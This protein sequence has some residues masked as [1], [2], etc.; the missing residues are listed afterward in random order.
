MNPIAKTSRFVSFVAGFAAIVA[1]G[2][3][4]TGS[5]EDKTGTL[6]ITFKLKGDAPKLENIEP[7]TDK[8]FCGKK[9]IPDESLV[10]NKKNK[11]IKN[12]IVYKYVSSRDIDRNAEIKNPKPKVVT[13]A[14][15]ACRFE[16]HVV[17][18][19]VQ[20]TI[21]VT[22]PDAVGHNANFTFIRNDQQNPTVPAGGSV[23]VVTTVNEPAPI[24]VTCNIHNWMKAYVLVLHPDHAYAG[25]SDADGVLEI[26][27][28]P[29]GEEIE[30]RANHE[31]GSLKEVIVGGK[32][33]EWSRSRFELTIKEGLNDMGV[34]E[35]PADAFKL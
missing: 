23:D 10:V 29:V 19:T 21:K 33:T 32:E 2:F 14:N 1:I 30:F 18:T 5:A 3:A 9:D 20:D 4:S 7:T 28:L 35:V 6:R 13:L 11:G 27:G 17:I 8:A 16:P 26:K 24:P 22:N 34:V 31:S 12:V 15:Q 25:V